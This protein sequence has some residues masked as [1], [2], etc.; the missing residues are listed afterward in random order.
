MPAPQTPENFWSRVKKS[1]TC[2]EWQGSR[3][4]T[5]YGTVA[6]GQVVYTA[7]RVAAWLSGLVDSPRAPK[8]KAAPGFVLHRCDNRLCC[9]PAHFFI[10]NYTDNQKDAYA[11]G[12]RSQPKGAK[13]ANAKLTDSQVREIRSRYSLGGVTQDDLA[14]E[15]GVS[16]R[17]ISLI[18]LKRTYADV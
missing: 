13:H 7:H 8:S 17:T 1:D 6:W 4:T 12:R 9:N 16:Q 18:I 14:A 11:K 3:N 5:G 15:F 2:W 10:G